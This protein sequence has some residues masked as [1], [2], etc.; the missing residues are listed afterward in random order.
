MGCNITTS[1]VDAENEEAGEVKTQTKH[2]TD[3]SVSEI[4]EDGELRTDVVAEQ[5]GVTEDS[6]GTDGVGRYTLKLKVSAA[7]NLSISDAYIV[8]YY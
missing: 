2:R 4:P 8:F 1:A 5:E 6:A 7:N 3:F